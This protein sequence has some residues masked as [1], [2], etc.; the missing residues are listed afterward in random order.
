MVIFLML[1]ALN[2]NPVL[3][4]PDFNNPKHPNPKFI[5]HKTLHNNPEHVKIPNT[6]LQV[7]LLD[8]DG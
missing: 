8:Y 2:N 7:Q 6:Y 5:N 1:V 4:N 3:N